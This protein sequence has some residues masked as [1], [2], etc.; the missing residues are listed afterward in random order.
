MMLGLRKDNWSNFNEVGDYSCGTGT[1][2]ADSTKV[3]VYQG[4][5]LIWGT[6]P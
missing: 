6:E 1:S 2:H 4:S 3:T 5:T